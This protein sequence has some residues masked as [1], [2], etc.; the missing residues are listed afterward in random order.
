M[1]RAPPKTLQKPP[2]PPNEDRHLI[3]AIT[4]HDLLEKGINEVPAVSTFW[5]KEYAKSENMWYVRYGQGSQ[6][7]QIILII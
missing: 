6:T 5:V 7:Q 1:E 2:P 4:L 3:W